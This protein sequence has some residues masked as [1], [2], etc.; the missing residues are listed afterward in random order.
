MNKHDLD[1]AG[2][3]EQRFAILQA[4]YSARFNFAGESAIAGELRD[5]GYEP[6]KHSLHRDLKYLSD[7]QLCEISKA[8]NGVWRARL[9]ANGCDLLEYTTPDVK[10]VL[11]PEGTPTPLHRQ[12]RI[13]RWRILQVL[14]LWR[15]YGAS[16]QQILKAINDIDLELSEAALRRE[17]CYLRAKGY[18]VITEGKR[19]EAQ[20]TAD[21]TDVEQYMDEP[22]PG[23]DRPSKYW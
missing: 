20:I 23:I 15:P 10:G 18:V 3:A 4:L 1:A 19:W 14:S 16:E 5:A 9:T 7:R 6:T 2:Y 12:F 17:L 13:A 11:R 22:G 8:A 21:G